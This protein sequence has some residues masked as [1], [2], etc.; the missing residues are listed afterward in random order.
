MQLHIEE[1]TENKLPRIINGSSSNIG[2]VKNSIVK[3]FEI[4]PKKS[5]NVNWNFMNPSNWFYSNK[6][7]N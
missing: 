2:A 3:N 5:L 1:E 7:G 4:D 6:I